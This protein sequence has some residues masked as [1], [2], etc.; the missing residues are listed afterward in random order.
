MIR[1]PRILLLDCP[2]EYKKGENQTAVELTKASDFAELLRQE[3]EVCF[4]D[5]L[6]CCRCLF[7][8]NETKYQLPTV[9][10]N[11]FFWF[12][13]RSIENRGDVSAAGVTSQTIF[14]IRKC[15]SRAFW[16]CFR[17]FERFRAILLCRSG[18]VSAKCH[19]WVFLLKVDILSSS[20]NNFGH[21]NDVEIS[22]NV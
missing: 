20:F 5:V 16:S 22:S 8:Q 3:E 4:L 7:C 18:H 6:C 14:Y 9:I 13:Y 19:V 1:N 2:L 21:K 15:S 12:V 17:A 11:S 10:R